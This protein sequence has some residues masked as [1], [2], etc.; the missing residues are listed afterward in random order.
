MLHHLA[1]AAQ[2]VPV[3]DI[4]AE[5]GATI[6]HLR[7]LARLD[8]IRLGDEA[9][10]RDSLADRDF[11]PVDPPLLTHDQTRL[12]RIKSDMLDDESCRV[13]FCC[14]ASQAAARRKLHACC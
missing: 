10:W 4:Y 9:V 13:P 2:P 7:K 8:L 1:T 3:T 14:M 11:V 5:T 6:T 12:G